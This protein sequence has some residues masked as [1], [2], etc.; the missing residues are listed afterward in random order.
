MDSPSAR[1]EEPPTTQGQDNEVAS[2]PA[3]GNA[4]SPCCHGNRRQSQQT[5]RP[6]ISLSHL[7][8][9]DPRSMSLNFHLLAQIL[10]L[11]LHKMYPETEGGHSQAGQGTTE[12]KVLKPMQERPCWGARGVGTGLK[13]KGQ[14]PCSPLRQEPHWPL[15]S[16]I[17]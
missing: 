8:H 15:F 4:G 12:R 13:K 6:P 14:H 10:P 17:S 3:A 1:K 5:P 9:F 11:A 7:W 2:R 16:H